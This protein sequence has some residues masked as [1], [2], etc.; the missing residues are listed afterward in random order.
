[1]PRPP[2]ASLLLLTAL[3]LPAL[4]DPGAAAIRVNPRTRLAYDTSKARFEVTSLDATFTAKTVAIREGE[5]ALIYTVP[6]FRAR[7][8]IRCLRE[9]ET[10]AWKLGFVQVLRQSQIVNRYGQRASRW[11]MPKLPL[12]DTVSEKELPWY[13]GDKG[14]ARGF[15]IASTALDDAPTGTVSWALTR[16]GPAA[17]SAIE[18]SQ[19]FSTYLC[20]Y[21]EA[22]DTLWILR[23]ISWRVSATIAVDVSQPIGERAKVRAVATDA[24]VLPWIRG[25]ETSWLCRPV[26]NSG[27]RLVRD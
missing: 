23:E 5:G 27:Q 11:V 10:R 6:N 17:L 16:E 7:A 21:D 9:D 12:L 8:K 4:A 15:G 18:R 3:A 1:M 25:V 22:N 2:H 24:K 14:Y 20:A 26:A 19:V 13:G